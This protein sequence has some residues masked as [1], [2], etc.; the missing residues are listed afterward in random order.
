MY[1]IHI[2]IMNYVCMYRCIPVYIPTNICLNTYIETCTPQQACAKKTRILLHI[3]IHRH[4]YLYHISTNV[5]IYIYVYILYIHTPIVSIGFIYLSICHYLLQ[6]DL[7]IC[8]YTVC[9]NMF[10]SHWNMCLFLS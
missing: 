6:T 8:I 9:V 10:S 2:D 4:T 1:I 7:H 5:Y 3:C